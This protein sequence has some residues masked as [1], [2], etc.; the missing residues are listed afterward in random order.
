M[1]RYIDIQTTLNFCQS[2][3]RPLSANPLRRYLGF[4]ADVLLEPLEKS[5]T[6]V[7]TLDVTYPLQELG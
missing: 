4:T 1:H 5:A 3:P 2:I 7:G 6:C